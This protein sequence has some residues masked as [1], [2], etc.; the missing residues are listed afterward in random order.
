MSRARTIRVHVRPRLRPI[1]SLLLRD[2]LAITVGSHIWAWRPLSARELAHET[3]HARQWRRHGM[4]FPLLY[5]RES[6]LAGR[7]GGDWYRDNAFEREATAAES[8]RDRRSG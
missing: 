8:P 3:A 5:L 4:W 1:G 6:V 7:R 2:W